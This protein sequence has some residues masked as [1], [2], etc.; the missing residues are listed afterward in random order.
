MYLI[1]GLGNPGKKYARTRHNVGWMVLGC[2]LEKLQTPNSKLQ[3]N[4]SLK[5]KTCKVK[6]GNQQVVLAKPLTYMNNSGA[7]VKS[8]I[9]NYELRITNLYLIHDDLDISLGSFK[10]QFG[11][12]PKEHKG[13][14]SV[15]KALGTKKFWRVRIGIE[16]RSPQLLTPRSEFTGEEYV[17]RKFKKEEMKVLDRVTSE[18]LKTLDEHISSQVS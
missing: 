4:K 15:E 12:G 2:L 18:V 7:A 5:S 14:E 6:I 10:I 9:T 8:L 13:V 11:K 3:T 16:N 17:L 1:V